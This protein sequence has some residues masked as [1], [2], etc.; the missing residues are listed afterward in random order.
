M[1]VDELIKEG[2]FMFA[3]YDKIYDCH[4][5][6]KKL[7]DEFVFLFPIVRPSFL[8][9]KRINYMTEAYYIEFLSVKDDMNLSN[10]K[11]LTSS[12][13]VRER[14]NQL[15]FIMKDKCKEFDMEF[16]IIEY[17]AITPPNVDGVEYAKYFIMNQH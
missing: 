3:H 12:E 14:Y 16:N 10:G 4:K 17:S 2:K 11:V 13:L 6:A 15:A 7:T 9:H 1:S 8:K 5:V